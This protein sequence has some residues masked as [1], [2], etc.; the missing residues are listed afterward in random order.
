MVPCSPQTASSLRPR[1]KT[2]QAHLDCSGLEGER[3]SVPGFHLQVLLQ[4][5]VALQPPIR[6]LLLELQLQAADGG[7][8]RLD[9][10]GACEAQ[11]S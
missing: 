4:L 1:R 9:G 6:L 5:P 11:R 7:L 3:P 2:A 8:K 10:I